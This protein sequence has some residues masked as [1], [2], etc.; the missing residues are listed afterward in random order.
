MNIPTGKCPK[1]GAFVRTAHVERVELVSATNRRHGLA[2]CCPQIGCRAVLG[3]QMDPEALLTDTVQE[4]RQLLANT[5]QEMRQ[6]LV[7][8]RY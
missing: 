4:M 8:A 5:A 7:R 1:C 6:L 2:Y 3:V